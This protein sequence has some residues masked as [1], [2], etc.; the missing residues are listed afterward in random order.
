MNTC[1]EPLDGEHKRLEAAEPSA[2]PS[3]LKGPVCSSGTPRVKVSRSVQ[4]L[5]ASSSS[6]HSGRWISGT[7]LS[8]KYGLVIALRL[9]GP[10]KGRLVD[11]A[12]MRRVKLC[13]TPPC[14]TP[15]IRR[16]AAIHATLKAD[17]LL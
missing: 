14:L 9:S 15:R 3:I 6:A 17:Q 12:R 10:V 11:L 7:D 8:V 13:P 2:Q 1:G 5:P 4:K 16:G